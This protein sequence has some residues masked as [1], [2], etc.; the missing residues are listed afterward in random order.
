MAS[1][2]RREVGQQVEDSN[3]LPSYVLLLRS[4]SRFRSTSRLQPVLLATSTFCSHMLFFKYIIALA[5][6]AWES[7]LAEALS[8][9]RVT[10]SD[11]L[12]AEIQ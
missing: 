10:C 5:N 1:G 11:R 7:M 8:P 4:P 6:E 2:G 9:P 12:V 3:P